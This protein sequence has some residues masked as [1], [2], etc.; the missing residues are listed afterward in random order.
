MATEDRADSPPTRRRRWPIVLGVVAAVVLGVIVC[1]PLFVDWYATRWLQERGLVDADIEDIDLDL[2]TGRLVIDG[3][4]LTKEDQRRNRATRTFV[5]L[6]WEGLFRER[7]VIGRIELHDAEITVIRDEAR[8]F[9]IANFLV[10]ASEREE[11]VAEDPEAGY[12]FGILEVDIRNVLVHYR[13][14]FFQEDVLFEELRLGQVATW[15]PEA[16]APLTLRAR[17]DERVHTI[18]GEVRPLAASPGAELALS[19][20]AIELAPFEAMLAQAG[21]ATIGGQFSADAQ[22]TVDAG[23]EGEATTA[24]VDGAISFSNVSLDQTKVKLSLPFLTTRKPTR[25]RSTI[26][27]HR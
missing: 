10:A 27:R 13:G 7:L 23:A 9:F 2:F 6:N 18:E 8:D 15:D 17:I 3:L 26:Q 12:D 19:F 1:L 21:V 5:D 24:E 25:A 4:T 14:Q 11:E 22:L 20:D 16:S